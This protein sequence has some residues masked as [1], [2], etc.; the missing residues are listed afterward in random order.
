[1]DLFKRENIGFDFYGII[2]GYNIDKNLL[3][4]EKSNTKETYLVKDAVALCQLTYCCDPNRSGDSCYHTASQNWMPY[5]PQETSIL[6]EKARNLFDDYIQARYKLLT[7]DPNNPRRSLL[8]NIGEGTFL[9]GLLGKEINIQKEIDSRL[10]RKRTGFFSMLYYRELEGRKQL[11]YV[12]VGT[13]FNCR[14]IYDLFMDNIVVNGG[15]GL[16]GLSPQHTLCIQNAKILNEICCANGWELFFFGHSLGGGLAIACGLATG[17]LTIVFNNAGLNILRNISHGSFLRKQNIYCF[18]TDRDFLSTEK[19]NKSNPILK[20]LWKV[21][22]PQIV[23][24][25]IY[26]GTGGHDIVGICQV[27]GLQTFN[28]KKQIEQGI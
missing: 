5:I 1:M 11:A 24:E 7:S 16:T 28:D 19:E 23:G 10:S 6:S 27:F 22:T 20:G 2:G 25:R 8:Q 4:N 18:F 26:L 13:T 17:Q 15:Q 9:K 3:N 14:K 12:P 21:A